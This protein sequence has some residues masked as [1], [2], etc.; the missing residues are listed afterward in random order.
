MAQHLVDH[1]LQVA[2]VGLGYEFVEILDG[3]EYRVH[4]AIVR[5]V[6]AKILHRRGKEGRQ[7]DGIHVQAGDVIEFGGYPRQVTNAIAIGIVEAAWI[8]LINDGATP[9]VRVLHHLA[10]LNTLAVKDCYCDSGKHPLE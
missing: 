5:H 9:P 4:A 6:V 10:S 8:N 1:D 7:P 3:A 2:F